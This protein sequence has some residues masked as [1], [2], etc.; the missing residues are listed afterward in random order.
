MTLPPP[1][2]THCPHCV[3]GRA[4]RA[5]RRRPSTLVVVLCGGGAGAGE[6]GSVRA[7][8]S[9]HAR[10]HGEHAGRLCELG[11]KASDRFYRR[12][13]AYLERPGPLGDDRSLH[14][15]AAALH[16]RLHRLLSAEM[17]A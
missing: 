16:Q 4:V 15:Q 13:N 12:Q 7:I 9:L 11:F 2:V 6:E 17:Q 5:T 8:C 1:I 14:L 3:D 10:H